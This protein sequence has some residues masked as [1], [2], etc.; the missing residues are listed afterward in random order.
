MRT[1]RVAFFIAITMST[2]LSSVLAEDVTLSS[3]EQRGRPAGLFHLEASNSEVCDD[4]LSRLNSPYPGSGVGAEPADVLLHTGA[5]ISW[6]TESHHALNG[7]PVEILST[8]L[9]GVWRLYSKRT[10]LHDYLITRFFYVTEAE[11]K[12]ARDKSGILSLAF[13]QSFADYKSPLRSLIEISTYLRRLNGG[14]SDYYPLPA[15][16]SG[17]AIALGDT[18]YVLLGPPY[19]LSR[20]GTMHPN[21]KLFLAKVPPDLAEETCRFSN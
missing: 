9:N 16:Y 12:A 8:Q 21:M 5:E 6:Q 10:R 19:M 4:V 3:L 18:V 17:N 14:K 7:G 20:D 13:I 11:A 1:S 15:S 2:S